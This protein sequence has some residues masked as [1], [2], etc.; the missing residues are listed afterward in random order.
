M[1]SKYLARPAHE[2][3]DLKF[4]EFFE[5]FNVGTRPPQARQRD[6]GC[7]EFV[8]GTQTYY[9][10]VPVRQPLRFYRIVSIFPSAG[11][12]FYLRLLLLHRST[13]SL[14]GLRKVDDITYAT[15][16]QAARRLGLIEDADETFQTLRDAIGGV[17][18][19]A[20][21]RMFACL[22]VHGFPT[23]VIYDEDDG[24]NDVMR[25]STACICHSIH[26]NIN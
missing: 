26:S 21:R 17:S 16:Q 8:V 3:Y 4:H 20:L 11:E 19:R 10:W 1:L 25:Y 13:R 22:T 24:E 7:D 18:P 15:Y 9:C 23:A 6:G 2:R 12:T 5:R 14:A